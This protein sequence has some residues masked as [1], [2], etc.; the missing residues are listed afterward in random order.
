MVLR[1]GRTA[2]YQLAREFLASDGASGL[3]VIRVGKQLR[4]PRGV[5]ERWMGG[6]IHT[7]ATFERVA[8]TPPTIERVKS[9][10]RSTRELR[11]EQPSIPFSA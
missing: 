5:L 10:R 8:E 3:P 4:V 6:P 11:S 2:A 1:I 7:P 9:R